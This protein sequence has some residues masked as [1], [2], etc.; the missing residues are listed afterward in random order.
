MA[1]DSGNKAILD[2]CTI[3]PSTSSPA[4]TNSYNSYASSNSSKDPFAN[5]VFAISASSVLSGYG[6]TKDNT[7]E[8]VFA[9][10]DVKALVR[11]YVQRA[12][13]SGTNSSSSNIYFA[14]KTYFRISAGS[15]S[16]LGGVDNA[17]RIMRLPDAVGTFSYVQEISR[18]TSSLINLVISSDNGTRVYASVSKSRLEVTGVR[19]NCGKEAYASGNI[20]SAIDSVIDMHR[21]SEVG[22]KVDDSVKPSGKGNKC[23]YVM[24][25]ESATVWCEEATDSADD[26][27]LVIVDDWI[28][29]SPSGLG[30]VI[31]HVQGMRGGR[32]WDVREDTARSRSQQLERMSMTPS[33]S[34]PN[35][36]SSSGVKPFLPKNGTATLKYYA[37]EPTSPYFSFPSSPLS[38]FAFPSPLQSTISVLTTTGIH[39]LHRPSILSSL[40]AAIVQGDI[41]AFVKAY[42]PVETIA[43]LFS[44][45]DSRRAMDFAFKYA[46]TPKLLEST[47][48]FSYLHDGLVKYISR[49][50]R[51]VWYKSMVNVSTAKASTKANAPPP[52][53]KVYV[54]VEGK[55]LDEIRRPLWELAT[56]MREFFRPALEKRMNSNAS[57]NNPTQLD[58]GSIVVRTMMFYQN[59]NNPSGTPVPVSDS[60]SPGA[61]KACEEA[62]M[63]SLYRLVTRAVHLLSLLDLL[64]YAHEVKSLPPVNWA[65]ISGDT[66][67]DLCCSKTASDNVKE[68]LRALTSAQDSDADKFSTA[69]HE[70]CFTYYS[71]GDKL[72]QE[73]VNLLSKDVVQSGV[74]LRKAAAWWNQPQDTKEDSVFL[75]CVDLLFEYRRAGGIGGI[76]DV[77]VKVAANFGGSVKGTRGE[78][79]EGGGEGVGVLSNFGGNNMDVLEWERGLYHEDGGVGGEGGGAG[80]GSMITVQQARHNAYGKMLECVEKLVGASEHD[81]ADLMISHMVSSEDDLLH[82]ELYAWLLKNNQTERLIR[83]SG[84][85]RL[86]KYLLEVDV[87]LLWRHYVVHER[88]EEASQLMSGRGCSG[89]KVRLDERMA[90][91]SR[92]GGDDLENKERLE[93]AGLQ[94]MILEQLKVEAK[95]GD[96]ER[97]IVED[98]E[99]RLLGVNEM[100]NDLAGPMGMWEICLSILQCCEMRDGEGIALLWKAL[101]CECLPQVSGNDLVQAHLVNLAEGVPERGRGVEGGFD[102][103][104]W[105]PILKNRVVEVGRNHFG[106]GST[107]YIV[108]LD[109]LVFELEGLRRCWDE[110]KG[111]GGAG[112]GEANW[113]IQAL[114]EVGV[115]YGRLLQVYMGVLQNRESQAADGAERLHYLGGIVEVVVRWVKFGDKD[116]LKRAMA[117][118]LRSV[119]DEVKGGLEALSG[120]EGGE[121]VVEHLIFQ[122]RSVEAILR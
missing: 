24:V 72:S 29:R 96:V 82:A 83:I 31:D 110:V 70:Q 63:N 117:Q 40:S 1:Q 6:V 84:S 111:E 85:K 46:G 15:L 65:L 41:S 60:T 28:D 13:T 37:D 54:Q 48:T 52:A 44:L 14:D 64:A 90:C 22:I 43:M 93:V 32:V 108:P 45:Q 120:V 91:F 8:L 4:P 122:M 112:G 99:Y 115:E 106:K 25:G 74:V 76:V 86:E 49:L 114:L 73:G 121:G 118:G 3:S 119:V 19:L 71:L 80:G 50:L 12:V 47:V 20:S 98:V 78:E 87:G 102:D 26:K 59:L 7:I 107:D 42:G 38:P 77:C 66:F 75:R 16:N 101:I 79:D 103:G 100:Y 95:V 61:M 81:L 97:D 2:M 94:K 105:I 11:A 33:D 92:V 116:S 5:Y 27:V 21:R 56:K 62:S 67:K 39:Y 58:T 55:V 88:K 51:P 36:S 30:E 69:L 89:E 17:R 23:S 68:L 57:T 53:S 113:V 109:M 10:L 9:S 35:S 34:P 104:S 18:N